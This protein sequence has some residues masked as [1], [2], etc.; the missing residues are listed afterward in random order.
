MRS[1]VS[2][3]KKA[4]HPELV[5]GRGID[6]PSPALLHPFRIAAAGTMAVVGVRMGRMVV[7]VIVIVTMVM[8][9][10]IMIVIVVM[11]MIVMVVVAVIGVVGVGADALHVVVVAGLGQADLGL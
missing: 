2:A 6:M 10:V 7:M 5:E 11:I 1:F 9:M 3:T 4:P 8:I